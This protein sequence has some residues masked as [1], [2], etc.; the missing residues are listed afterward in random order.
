MPCTIETETQINDIIAGTEQM[1]TEI[2]HTTESLNSHTHNVSNQEK[3]PQSIDSTADRSIREK[4]FTHK[5]IDFRNGRTHQTKTV[6]IFITNHSQLMF[7]NNKDN[8]RKE[9]I[10]TST[11]LITI[12]NNRCTRKPHTHQRLA[13]PAHLTF[14]KIFAVS[15]KI[16]FEAT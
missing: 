11:H 14:H 9:I 16:V 12:N 7:T 15:I 10:V 4:A 1:D 5:Q 3:S 6:A 2:H 8:N 13:L